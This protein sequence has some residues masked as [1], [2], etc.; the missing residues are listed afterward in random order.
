MFAQSKAIKPPVTP[1]LVLDQ[2]PISALNTEDGESGSCV[3]SDTML[4]P[5]RHPLIP[6][7]Q[8]KFEEVPQ[9]AL[10]IDLDSFQIAL[11]LWCQDSAITRQQYAGLLE[12]LSLLE[13]TSQ[14]DELPR[15]IDALRQ[16]TKARLPLM[17]LRRQQIPL[18]AAKLPTAGRHFS[19]TP[20]DWLYFFDPKYLFTTLLSSDAFKSKLHLGMAEFVDEAKELWHSPSWGASIRACSGDYAYHD[21][22]PV[23]LSDVVQYRCTNEQCAKL[24]LGRVT[25]SGRDFSSFAPKA[26]S[27]TL[28]VQ[29]LKPAEEM[30]ELW[31]AALNQ[32]TMRYA[33]QPKELIYI[34]DEQYFI[35]KDAVMGLERNVCLDY[36][37]DNMNAIDPRI[38]RFDSIIIRRVYNR[39]T[40][41]FRPLSMSPPIR[42]KLEIAEFGHQYLTE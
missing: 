16:R 36:H 19:T 5:T 29:C 37:F 40:S 11:G 28:Q 24:H 2:A 20:M 25:C 8:D 10:K 9:P 13:T 34:E 18:V 6:E 1:P 38:G 15:S 22:Q 3:E 41:T 26:G 33:P 42:G 7:S 35:P 31:L 21:N 30:Q 17:K 4:P 32:G 14:I 39:M 23:F 12:V 27:V